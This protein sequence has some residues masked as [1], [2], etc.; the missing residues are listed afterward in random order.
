[1]YKILQ[2][3]LV[4]LSFNALAQVN[5][6]LLGTLDLNTI[7]NTELNDIWGYVDEDGNEYAI[8]GAQNG[9]SI[10]D[11]TDPANPVEV[12]WEPGLNSIWRDIKTF[13]DYAY[14]TTEAQNGLLIIDLGP[15]PQST[16]LPTYYYNGPSGNEWESAH[17]LYV[18]DNTGFGYIFGAN[19][20]NG[21]LIILDLNP[22][23]TQPVEV[24][25]FED[26][27]SHDGFVRNDT[28]FLA[29]IS[30]GIISIVDVT[31]PANPQLLGTQTTP[32]NLAHN[33]WTTD[34]NNYAY[35]TDETPGGYLTA[36]DVSDPTNIQEIDKV[37]VFPGEQIIPHNT[38]VF[39]D[40]IVTSYYT[41]GVR[42]HDITQRGNMIEVASYDTSP[43]DSPTY[44]GC[45]GVYPY[46]PS[47]NI[48]ASDIEGGLSILGVTY[49]QAAY[50]E[51]NVKD[52]NNG[53][54]LV[55]VEV[56][57]LGGSNV[58]KF[59]NIQGNYTTGTIQSGSYDVGFYKVGYDSLVVS[60]VQ[61]TQGVLTVLDTVMDPLPTFPVTIN[62]YEQGTG[63]PIQ[64][65]SVSLTFPII[66]YLDNTNG[67]G[68]VSFDLYYNGT[69]EVSAG[70][71]GYK[72]Y[73][74]SVNFDTLNTTID[75]FLK[76]E[77]Y[78]DFTFDFGWSSISTADRGD[79]V[80]VI[81]IPEY[82]GFAEAYESPETD[83]TF[84]CGDYAYMTGNGALTNTDVK[85]GVVTLI[86]P[87]FDL[88]DYINP[89][90]SIET[91]FFNFHG[92]DPPNDSLQLYLSN[93][94]SVELIDFMTAT[95]SIGVWLN[96]TFRVE[97][98]MTPT[99]FMQLSVVTSDFNST[100][101]ITKGGI[102]RFHITD[103][104]PANTVGF[105]AESPDLYPNPA[106]DDIRINAS[107]YHGSEYQI[108][109]VNGQLVK[110]GVIETDRI[111]ISK[112]DAGFYLIKIKGIEKPYKI[113]KK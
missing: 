30:D 40:Y 75:I 59:T 54:N 11:V 78:D 31:D 63:N 10:V 72:T 46:L 41:A 87:V 57:I 49:E 42:I 12:F 53:N 112:L 86:S 88:T 38:H 13:G 85:N 22:N 107:G 4:F 65:A 3:V 15:L 37:R 102:D 29:H 55:D 67:L 66:E 21:G 79:W 17:N 80:R 8:V 96:K 76:K 56:E 52:A 7:H 109:T 19:R 71:W 93:G 44:N 82:D 106:L 24:G 97:D 104:N 33:I 51:G 91:F 43:L 64:D 28:A 61:L 50:L 95:D 89:Y 48:I 2:F 58:D 18:D 14:V 99:A 68:E 69:Y 84:D 5:T 20:D 110:N 98:I 113:I 26:W 105:S 23:P 6:Q 39:G 74:T 35:T 16:V 9:T 83:V 60:G 34:D 36:F 45:W 62:V 27:Y 100:E 103:G 47:G 70:K 32:T 92:F 25:T 77:Y 101:N 81:P 1:M 111:D 108:S 73:C 90:L 94:N